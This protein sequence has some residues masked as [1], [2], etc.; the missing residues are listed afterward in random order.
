MRKLRLALI[1]A[2]LD[3][4]GAEKQLA[5]LARR[6]DPA[7]F[8]VAVY[9]LTRG[10]PHEAEIKA[11]G[12]PLT[13]LHKAFKYDLRV[14][15]RLERL[16]KDRQTDIA[17]TWLF[18]A[19]AF[20]RAAAL[21]ARVPVIIAGEQDTGPKP[22]FHH[23]LDRRL[24]RRSDAIVA[25]SAGVREYGLAH[26]WPADKIRLIHA[27]IDPAEIELDKKPD[28]SAPLPEVPAGH[29]LVVT[30]C[31]LTRQKGLIYLMWAMGLLRHARCPV[32][33]WI[34]GDGPER[35]RL[36]FEI[37]RM[38]VEGYVTLLG[39]RTDVPAILRRAD[40]FVLPSFHE[41]MSNAVLEA[42]LAGVPVVVSDVA[43]MR[44]LVANGRLG[45]LVEPGYPKG[46]A[47]GIFQ[48]VKY[49]DETRRMA[50]EGVQWIRQEF[51]ADRFIRRHEELFIELARKKGLM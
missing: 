8:D 18:T 4:A 15:P 31:R 1:I 26:G 16:L 21:R 3:R 43:G 25:N 22:A 32:H 35:S 7:R 39:P 45:R 19:N 38:R 50:A 11:A 10:G 40:L 29:K 27:G 24:A 37:Q 20:G 47:A 42:M 49:E 28:L 36:A 33:L 14:V 48:A 44:E 23:W 51:S 13:I 9:A 6:L 46:I 5:L 34:V 30:A 17:Y 2:T 12:I 41:G